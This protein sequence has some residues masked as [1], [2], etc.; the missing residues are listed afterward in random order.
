L[1]SGKESEDKSRV[2]EKRGMDQKFFGGLDGPLASENIVASLMQLRVRPRPFAPNRIHARARELA[3]RTVL[4]VRASFRK[5]IRAPHPQAAYFQQKFP[6]LSL[7]EVESD[8]DRLKEISDRFQNV[9]AVEM[10]ETLFCLCLTSPE[11]K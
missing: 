10:G 7:T 4:P 1:T 6:S 2:E 9:H 5:I 11:K 8:M 3:V